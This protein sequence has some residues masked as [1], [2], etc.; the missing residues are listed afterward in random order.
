MSMKRSALA[1]LSVVAVMLLGACGGGGGSGD[2]PDVEASGDA[3]AAEDNEPVALREFIRSSAEKA[4][5]VDSS[6]L[7]M[8]MEIPGPGGTPLKLTA[9][10]AVDNAKT[11]AS[12]EMDMGSIAPEMAGKMTILVAGK[13]I[14]MR[15]PEAM[16]AP[17]P[18]AKIDLTQMGE[19]A[20]VDLDTLMSQANQA[21][22]RAMLGL[23]SAASD[24]VEEIGTE[25]VRGVATRHFK[26]TVDLQ[27]TVQDASEDVKAAMAQA[28]EQFGFGTYPAEVW[29]DDDDLPRRVAFS[30]DLSKAKIPGAEG[31]DPGAAGLGTMTIEMDMFD[32]GVDVDLEIPPASETMDMAEFMGGMGQGS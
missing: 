2:K 23:L 10:G 19:M 18:W 14:Y 29:I 8:R 24:D 4:A 31:I 7:E 15:F 1:S 20:G 5:G 11:L 3:E 30:M 17:K 27:R 13:T 21:D 26:M 25:D 9:T 22:P 32:Y 12:M 28:V 6:R 16:G